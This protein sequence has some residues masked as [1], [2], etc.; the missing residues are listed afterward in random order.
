M[1]IV[2]ND[3]IDGT[4]I[5]SRAGVPFD[6]SVDTVISRRHGSR[7][8]GGVI[9]KN[10][11]KASIC[12]HMAGLDPMWI[13]K[14]LIWAVFHYAFIQLKV[15]KFFAEVPASN[16]RALVINR[17][18]GFIEEA[19]IKD[20]FEDGDLIVLAMRPEQCKWLRLIEPKEIFDGIEK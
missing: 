17:K 16:H 20:V 1:S 4:L 2:V 6:T 7:L 15:R 19:R 11:T 10:Y 8:L 18:F 13:S 9:F 3:K 14:S 5:A 12:A